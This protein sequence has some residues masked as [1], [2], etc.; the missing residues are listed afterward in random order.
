ML[1]KPAVRVPVSS[2]FMCTH[3]ATANSNTSLAPT[4]ILTENP[5]F[6]HS[7]LSFS[8]QQDGLSYRATACRLQLKCDI[9]AGL[10]HLI[11]DA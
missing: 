1:P 6:N 9:T 2:A 5:D 7:T 8:Y 4:F 3:S 11:I 10:M